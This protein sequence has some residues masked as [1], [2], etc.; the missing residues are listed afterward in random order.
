[1]RITLK[2]H[3]LLYSA[4]GALFLAG[5]LQAGLVSAVNASGEFLE[6]GQSFGCSN[7]GTTTASCDFTASGP[8]GAFDDAS[9]SYQANAQYGSLDVT[10]RSYVYDRNNGGGDLGGWSSAS[11]SD[12]FLLTGGF[13]SGTL[14]FVAGYWGYGVSEFCYGGCLGAATVT[15]NTFT[16]DS[17]LGIPPTIVNLPFSFSFGTPFNLSASASAFS[18]PE[19]DGLAETNAHL[20]IDAIEV[21]DS[22]GALITNYGVTSG[23]GADYPF[24]T[25]EP[26]TF[27]LFIA[28]LIALP[29]IRR[30]SI[31]ACRRG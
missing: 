4:A 20:R 13:G 15:L 5:T 22:N 24:V 2:R 29:I 31:S 28:A 3:A 27:A 26:G 11:F 12:T 18:D 23:S 6:L 17:N 30:K 14:V 25:P 16:A 19:G 1:M 7:A 21:L 10:S 9:G 8:P